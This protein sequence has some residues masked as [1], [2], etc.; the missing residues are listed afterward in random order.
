M[1]SPQQAQVMGHL[2]VNGSQTLGLEGTSE[3]C[4]LKDQEAILIIGRLSMSAKLG[5]NDGIPAS[6]CNPLSVK[7][8]D[9]KLF[10][11]FC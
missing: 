7:K 6:R 1:G 9:M 8:Q 11:I 2:L 5:S 4:Q 10:G 3:S